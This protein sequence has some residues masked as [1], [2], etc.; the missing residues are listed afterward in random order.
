MK[1]LI[2]GLYIITCL[3]SSAQ[4]GLWSRFGMLAQHNKKL[5][6]ATT[7][8]ASATLAYQTNFPKQPKKNIYLFSHGLGGN[9]GQANY[10]QRDGILWQN[11]THAFNYPDVTDAS[12][13]NLGQE[14]DMQTLRNAYNK[15]KDT[16][17]VTVFG[18]SRGAATAINFLGT[19][20]CPEIKAAVLES[21]FDHVESVVRNK[22]GVSTSVVHP[23]VS[24]LHKKYNPNGPQPIKTIHGVSP[25][26]PVLIVCSEKDALIPAKSSQNL[27]VALKKNNHEHAYLLT[28]Q[29]GAHAQILWA[30]DGQLY[31]NTVHAF[32]KKYDLPH[33]ETWAQ[34]G[35]ASLKNCQPTIAEL[36]KP[37][38]Q[39]W[40]G[41]W[42]K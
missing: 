33:N 8:V 30:E 25:K 29:K 39:S 18:V 3:A 23:A 38:Q 6:A 9:Q 36:E 11:P 42:Y 16:G 35:E 1:K 32:Y 28:T 24:L 21:P 10:Y 27:Y 41:P 15:I 40:F 20:D 7:C 19:D 17:N 5:L 12:Q 14:H 37:K 22:V 34:Q 31:R 4:A 13:I 26:L 2:F